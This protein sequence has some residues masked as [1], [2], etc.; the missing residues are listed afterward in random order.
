MGYLIAFG[1]IIGGGFG[2]FMAWA[3]ARG[4]SMRPTPPITHEVLRRMD[5]DEDDINYGGTDD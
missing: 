5:E 1:V 4:G 2:A 3:I